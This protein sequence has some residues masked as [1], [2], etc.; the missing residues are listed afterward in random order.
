[1]ALP[2]IR[3]VADH[4]ETLDRRIRYLCRMIEQSAHRSSRAIQYDRQE[5][6]ALTVAV[7]LLRWYRAWMRGG[8]TP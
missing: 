3:D 2:E 1:M 8:E 4:I 7:Q 5:R 6:A